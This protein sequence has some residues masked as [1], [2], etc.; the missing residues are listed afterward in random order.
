MKNHE[1]KLDDLSNF[2]FEYHFASEVKAGK[3]SKRLM[4]YVNLETENIY[5]KVYRNGEVMVGTHSKEIAVEQYND[6]C[7]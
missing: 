2:D 4:I 7:L 3:G 1:I 5:Y 6:I